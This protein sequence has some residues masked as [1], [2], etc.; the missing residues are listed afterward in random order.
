MQVGGIWNCVLSKQRP[1]EAMKRSIFSCFGQ[2]SPGLQTGNSPAA[3]GQDRPPVPPML[4]SLGRQTG[5]RPTEYLHHDRVTLGQ[6][7]HGDV[8][9]GRNIP[10]QARTAPGA[11]ASAEHGGRGERPSRKCPCQEPG[12][13]FPETGRIR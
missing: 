4:P 8:G 13:S 12:A 11:E 6:G 9:R 7:G 2:L 5:I 1:R 10:E 3:G